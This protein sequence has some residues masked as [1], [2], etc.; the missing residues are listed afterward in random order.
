MELEELLDKIRL[1]SQKE[2][3]RLRQEHE[4]KL[5]KIRQEL[6][7]K[8]ESARKSATEKCARESVAEE[9]RLISIEEMIWRKIILRKKRAAVENAIE[10]GM[11]AFRKSKEYRK[12]VD[13]VL[14]QVPERGTI[15]INKDDTAVRASDQL[16][17][18]KLKIIPCGFS[19]GI[20]YTAGGEKII[21]SLD[22]LLERNRAN[23]E[24][25]IVATLFGTRV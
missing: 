21:I 25:E 19:G 6:K 9:R 7:E 14:K 11:Q 4:V 12:F 1:E 10:K 15:Y 13:A 16:R 22:S 2:S 3:E 23:V 8:K 18:K 5:K 20:A 17:K 24:R